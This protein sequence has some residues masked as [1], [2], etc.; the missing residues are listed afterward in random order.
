MDI[1]G[2]I[3]AAAFVLVVAYLSLKQ[4]RANRGKSLEQRRQE[5]FERYEKRIE[6]F[7]ETDPEANESTDEE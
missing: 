1:L 6:E 4:G 7:R 2:T 3:L 5:T